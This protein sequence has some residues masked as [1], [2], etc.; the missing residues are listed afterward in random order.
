MDKNFCDLNKVKS[1]YILKKL[2]YLLFK[3][4]SLDVIS[5]NKKFQN[6]FGINIDDYKKES[7]KLKIGEKNG[8]GK[9]YILDTYIL[10]FEGEYLN[11]KKMEKVRF[12]MMTKQLNLKVNF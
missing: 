5:Y 10:I 7:R 11:G 4:K 6:K 2:F 9:E 12:I 1:V 8:N 3:R